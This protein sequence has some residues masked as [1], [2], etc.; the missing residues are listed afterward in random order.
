MH[1]RDKSRLYHDLGELMKSGMTLSRA[2]ERL[3]LHTRGAPRSVLQ[4]VARGVAQG[5]TLAE[6]LQ[7]QRGI[8]DLDVA[9]FTASERAGKL[10][11]GFELA[12]QYYT[13]LAEARDR[14]LRKSAYPL[15][16]LHFAVVVFGITRLVGPSGGLDK[17][18]GGMIT[19]F[20]VL[21]AVLLGGIFLIRAI[22]KQG[23]SSVAV[24]RS[25]GLIPLIGG[26]R[27]DL[28]LSRLTA[29]YDMQ[30]EAGVNVLGAL[31]ASGKAS[32]S[33]AYRDATARAVVDVRSGEPVSTALTATRA[34]P[35]RFLRAFMVGEES[36]RL[37]HEL[38]ALSEEYRVGGL[39]KLESLSEWVPRLIFIA[40]AV[41]IGW[42]AIS[43]Y[44]GYFESVQ[45]LL[46]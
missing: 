5:K 10:D 24:D 7:D 33:A 26:M 46:K 13:A 21:W 27:R 4:G 15:F 14:I 39:R 2:V 29:A 32:A 11:R 3:V 30:L 40:V 22:R 38:R 31:E 43:F 41:I 44:V 17:V 36:G 45:Q 19:G 25:L 34:F 8:N 37:D 42:R 20:I 6:S 1:P 16:V 12:A 35:E 23:A 9:L 28:A 18:V